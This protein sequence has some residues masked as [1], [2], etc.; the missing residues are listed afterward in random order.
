M[1]SIAITTVVFANCFALFLMWM[2]GSEKNCLS[3]T[4]RELQILKNEEN[5]VN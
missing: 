4:E 5:K 3:R 1:I 2:C